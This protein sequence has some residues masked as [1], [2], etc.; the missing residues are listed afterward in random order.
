[1]TAEPRAF[2]AID[3]GA[4]TASAALIGRVAGR[5]RLLGSLAFPAAIELEP[6]LALLVERVR[7]A[8]GEIADSVG[9]GQ[10]GRGRGR[11]TGLSLDPSAVGDG[12][13][14]LAFAVDG[15]GAATD[16]P[17]VMAVSAPPGRLAVLAPTERRMA[18]LES[19]ATGAGWSVAAAS[20]DRSDA[21][22]MTSL[23]LDSRVSA[24]L[25]GAG[26]P[27]GSDERNQLKT[28]GPLLVAVAARRPELAIV[29]AGSA[30]ELAPAIEA[31][32]L[33]AA[34][35]IGA[36]L[37]TEAAGVGPGL[38]ALRAR[39]DEL[40]GEPLDGRRAMIQS[41]ATLS[42]LLRRRVEL[43]DLGLGG[44]L[45]CV[46]DDRAGSDIGAEVLWSIVAGAGLVSAEPDDGV[47][48][49]VLNWLVL[50][51]DR[52]RLRDRLRD[53]WLA[54]WA[55]A[56]GDGA[57]L[58]LA[59]A[60]ASLSRLVAATPEFGDLAAPDLL[61]AAGGVWAVAPAPAV[62]MALVDILRRQGVSQL[63]LD[64]ARL[65]GPLG[66][67]E[68][69]AERLALMADLIDDLLA[70]LGTAIVPQG[71]HQGR[72]VGRIVLHGLD[73]TV[74]RDLVGGRVETL[75]LPVGQT[76]TAELEFRDGVLLGGRGKRFAMEVAGG[77]GG[78]LVDLR[79][80]PLRLPDRLDHRRDLLASW[81]RSVWNTES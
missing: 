71:L 12:P 10:G 66:T 7:R 6:V 1:M 56:H 50:P 39:L 21:L 29:L 16:L 25:V 61:V 64:H 80:I 27:L 34:G 70:P 23:A 31:V 63:A 75:D 11:R 78:L 9:I 77:M 62:A 48:D 68:D 22:A 3:L 79:D 49:G 40:R 51:V 69:D 44:A 37:V 58:R 2:F 19:A 72:A 26:V 38:G 52:P 24:V 45:R 53:F 55:E 13:L 4:A 81:Q 5:W 76:A 42:A 17:R 46:A 54:P 43:V 60:R 36:V 35:P 28:L 73:E 65:L 20:A 15:L 47:V 41:T 18:L 59:L 33:E 57:I 74:G 14:D 30:G 67:I 8:D 32:R